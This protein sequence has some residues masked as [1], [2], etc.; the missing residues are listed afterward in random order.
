[1]NLY[2]LIKLFF[3]SFNFGRWVSVQNTHTSLEGTLSK[4]VSNPF[5]EEMRCHLQI[6]INII[7]LNV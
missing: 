2:P 6:T 7:H 4:Q 1:M 5:V 3:C